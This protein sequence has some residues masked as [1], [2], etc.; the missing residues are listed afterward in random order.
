MDKTYK[1]IAQKSFLGH[2]GE[3]RR[4]NGHVLPGDLL[5][6]SKQR[7]QALLSRNLAADAPVTA[8]KNKPV[9][10]NKMAGTAPNKALAGDAGD[11]SKAKTKGRGR[12]AAAG[13]KGELPLE[14]GAAKPS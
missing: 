9:P 10:P 11:A 7:R 12:K 3:S 13:G 6:T 1:L 4:S 2:P 14:P 8:V 5:V